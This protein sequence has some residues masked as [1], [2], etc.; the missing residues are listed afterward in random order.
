ML[1]QAAA[2]KNNWRAKHNAFV[3]AIRAAREVRGPN[4]RL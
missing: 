3:S 1:A 4:Q 2:K